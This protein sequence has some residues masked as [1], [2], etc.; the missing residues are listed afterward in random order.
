MKALKKVSVVIPVYNSKRYIHECI[1]ATISQTYNNLEILIVDD[2]S[3]DLTM[4][5]CRSYANTDSRIK[6]F[7]HENIGV[8]ATRNVGIENATGD[9]IVF[10]DADDYP[11]KELIERYMA[12]YDEWNTKSISFVACGMFFDNR[13]NKRVEN[14]EAVLEPVH[15]YIKGENY[16]L[17][18]SSA[19][20]LSWLRIFNFV[21]N[22]CYDLK[23][24]KENNIAFD[25][26][27]H[28]GED[29]KF[30]LDY[31][32]KI[33]GNI[34][35]INSPLYH[36]VKR[37]DNSLSISYHAND[38]DD[39]KAIYKRF[40]E[41]EASQ[42][43]VTEDNILVVKGVFVTDW[44]N[45]LTSMYEK[46]R[47]EAYWEKTSRKIKRELQSK[48]FK[49]LLFEVYKA[50]KI[51]RLRYYTLKIGFFEIFVFFRLV[52]QFMKG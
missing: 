23:K 17:N 28:I 16:L 26:G 33:S 19:S 5:I 35:M 43:G 32:D 18:R 24:I 12:A 13:Y 48:E 4:D 21:T 41:W 45:R 39:T 2:G 51:S 38:L 10:F 34:G 9:Y 7:T 52:Y 40:I 44:V 29:L 6:L 30:N 46:Y 8:S 20:T 14:R 27:V 42:Q 15:G 31:L 50:G 22:K 3:T 47:H 25:V 1:S 37:S 49:R 36:Y 11:E